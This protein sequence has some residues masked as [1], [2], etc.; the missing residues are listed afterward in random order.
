MSNKKNYPKF[1]G[2]SGSTFDITEWNGFWDS[3]TDT[4]RQRIRDKAK[5]EACTVSQVLYNWPSIL[6][7]V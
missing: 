3:L 2:F 4:Q 6:Q 5:W 1:N 7:G